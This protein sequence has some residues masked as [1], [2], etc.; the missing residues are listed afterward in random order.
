[1]LVFC[2]GMNVSFGRKSECTKGACCNDVDIEVQVNADS[3]AYVTSTKVAPK[4]TSLF[5]KYP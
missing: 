4:W 5:S 3:H 2:F 1:M